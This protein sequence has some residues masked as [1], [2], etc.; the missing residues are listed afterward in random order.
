[1]LARVSLLSAERVSSASAAVS[2]TPVVNARARPR[3]ATTVSTTSGS[4]RRLTNAA[5]STPYSMPNMRVSQAPLL[6]DR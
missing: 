1:M 6:R 2:S 5:R 4:R 3:V